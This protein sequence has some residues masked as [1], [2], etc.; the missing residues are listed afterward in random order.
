MPVFWP[1]PMP[2]MRSSFLGAAI[3]VRPIAM[4]TT[5]S[6][7]AVTCSSRCNFM[8]NSPGL[9]SRIKDNFDA[10]ILLL[11]EDLVPV[12]G[13]AQR[14]AVRHDEARIDP[15]AADVIQQLRHVLVYV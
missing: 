5:P 6:V 7:R 12:R 13:L 1:S 11:A 4:L 14:Q 10:P 2:I 15:P 8:I 3:S 9:R